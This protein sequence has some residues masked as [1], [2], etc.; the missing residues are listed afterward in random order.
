MT[1]IVYTAQPPGF[2]SHGDLDTV[3]NLLYARVD[4]LHQ[5]GINQWSTWPRWRPE[6]E[7]AI[8]EHRVWILY[9]DVSYTPVGTMTVS[10]DGDEDFWTPV[11]RATPA[12][13]LAKLATRPDHAG[14][15]LGKL[16]LE[17]AMYKARSERLH[18][19]RLDVWRNNPA[20]CRY[21]QQRGWAYLRT[22]NAPERYSGVLLTKQVEPIR[23]NCPPTGLE[24][25]PPHPEVIPY[26]EYTMAL[27]DPNLSQGDARPRFDG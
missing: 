15:G 2:Y 17:F 22:V 9:E 3:M 1:Y 27:L 14:K 8:T 10:Y 18:E 12:L 7:Q 21:Y 24:I 16:L 4:W 26:D 23:I 11:E 6:I 25:R 5:R 13:Y 19:V 20:L